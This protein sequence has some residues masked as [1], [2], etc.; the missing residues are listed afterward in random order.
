[1]RLGIDFG[2]TRTRVAAVLK[3]NY[4]LI[5]PE[6]K[7]ESHLERVPVRHWPEAPL[8]WIEERYQCDAQGIIEVTISN[9]TAGYHRTYRI[10]GIS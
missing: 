7:Q 5:D 4:P 2:T 3:G 9:Q 1:M 10:R 8:H 6:L